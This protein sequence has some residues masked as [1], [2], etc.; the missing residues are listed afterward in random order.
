MIKEVAMAKEVVVTLPNK[1]GLLANMS[2]ILA[3]RGINVEGVAGYA[4]NGEAKLMFLADDTLRAKE[5]LQGGGYKS[6]KEHD[7]IVIDLENK[8]GALKGMTAKLAADNIDIAYAY[9]TVCS[10]SCPAKLV[11]STSDNEKAAVILKSK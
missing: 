3:D 8:P 5:A 10:G 11:I 7:V 4:V 9:G 2:K 1:V 6:I